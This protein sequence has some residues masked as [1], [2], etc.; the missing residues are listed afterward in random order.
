MVG[1]LGAR[2]RKAQPHMSRNVIGRDAKSLVEHQAKQ[3]LRSRISLLGAAPVPVGGKRV[4][5]RHAAP[6][7]IHEAKEGLRAR[8]AT[9]RRRSD[10]LD[11]AWK[12][13][14]AVS[15][16]EW[17]AQ[18]RD[19]HPKGKRQAEHKQPLHRDPRLTS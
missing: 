3:M 2:G 19:R 11:G 7:L 18:R 13:A 9:L 5:L 16:V 6:V 4:V 14:R 10:A 17:R 12:V 1:A 15:A 8:I